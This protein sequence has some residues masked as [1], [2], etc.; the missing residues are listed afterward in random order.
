MTTMLSCR[1][2]A[3]ACTSIRNRSALGPACFCSTLIATSRPG[4]MSRVTYTVPI[5]PSPSLR[6]SS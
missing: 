1:Q 5:P 2:R 3:V 4:V 6:S